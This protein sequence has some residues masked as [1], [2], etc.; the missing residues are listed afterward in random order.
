M[1]MTKAVSAEWARCQLQTKF[2]QEIRTDIPEVQTAEVGIQA[3]DKLEVLNIK[4]IRVTST[5]ESGSGH[6]YGYGLGEDYSE[7]DSILCGHQ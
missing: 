3:G 2:D 7:G 5:P 6:Q 4:T 1:Q